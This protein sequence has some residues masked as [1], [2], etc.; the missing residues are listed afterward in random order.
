MDKNIFENGFKTTQ[1]RSS[2]M[3][4]SD[5]RVNWSEIEELISFEI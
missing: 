3:K 4:L 1:I 5:L 2:W